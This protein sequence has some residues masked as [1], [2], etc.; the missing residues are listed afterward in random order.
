MRT[1]V[2]TIRPNARIPYEHMFPT[3]RTSPAL[4]RAPGALRKLRSLLLL[5]YD[6]EVDW[7]VDQEHAQ[8]PEHPHRAPLRDSLRARARPRRPGQS[9]QVSHACLSP[10]GDARPWTA[11]ERMPR[12]RTAAQRHC[13]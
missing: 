13:E 8:P 11:Q 6:N 3:R 4:Q 5:E 7:E 1:Y 10:V 2:R 12:R 9:V